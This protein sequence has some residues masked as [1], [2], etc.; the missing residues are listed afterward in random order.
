ALLESLKVNQKDLTKRIT[1]QVK[2]LF[3]TM[4]HIGI[5][6]SRLKMNVNEMHKEVLKKVSKE[7]IFKDNIPKISTITN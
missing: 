4:F 7:E 2:K 5:T 1:K 6:N 3:T